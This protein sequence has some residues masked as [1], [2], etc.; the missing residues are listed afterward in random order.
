MIETAVAKLLHLNI[1]AQA[2]EIVFQ[3]KDIGALNGK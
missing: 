3:V 2:T 1:F